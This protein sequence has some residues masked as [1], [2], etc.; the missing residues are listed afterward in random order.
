MMVGYQR[1]ETFR[2]KDYSYAFFRDELKGNSWL[3]AYVV[4]VFA[5]ASQF[6]TVEAGDLLR[7][8]DWLRNTQNPDT[9]CFRKIG[10]PIHKSMQVCIN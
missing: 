9:G 8:I 7:S 10:K 3:T 5:F 2:L 6:M 1:Q 4:R